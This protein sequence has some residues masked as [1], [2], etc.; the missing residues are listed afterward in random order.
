MAAIDAQAYFTNGLC[1]PAGGLDGVSYN[2]LGLIVP[3]G[4]AGGGA[5]SGVR[6][7]RNSRVILEQSIIDMD[8]AL[9]LRIIRMWLQNK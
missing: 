1:V 4:G 8:D 7:L 2:T 6:R 5:S 9:I 3:E